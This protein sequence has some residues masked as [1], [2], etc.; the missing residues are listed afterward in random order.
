MKAQLRKTERLYALPRV[1]RRLIRSESGSFTL[2][3]ALVYPVIFLLIVSIL[4]MSKYVYDLSALYEKAAETAERTA[5]IWDNSYKDW[6]TGISLPGAHDPLYWR[7]N[8]SAMSGLFGGHQG[9]VRITW[10]QGIDDSSTG[11]ASRSDPESKLER[12]AETLPGQ[13]KG[14]LSYHHG[15]LERAVAVELQQNALL[16]LLS[17]R[18]ADSSLKAKANSVV[19]EP[20]ELIRNVDFV[21]TFIARIKDRIALPKAKQ[22]M[23]TAAAPEP[24]H[25][26]FGSEK[27]A[28]AYLRK[29]VGGTEATVDTPYGKRILNALDPD[30]LF[31]EVKYGYQAKTKDAEKQIAKDVEL[32]RNSTIIKG[33]VWHFFRNNRTGKI[34]P[35]KPLRK[36]LEESGIIVV[37]HY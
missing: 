13:L 19:T 23:A 32:I 35:S 18:W 12:A 27:E 26:S 21:R 4:F 34:G 7:T 28:A 20:V 29:L 17:A 25:L 3:S 1:R 22:A 8:F 33:V 31:H 37:I 10:P 24:E 9:E 5:Y 15:I 2:E 11:S 14:S 16:P 6:E 36:K 30:G